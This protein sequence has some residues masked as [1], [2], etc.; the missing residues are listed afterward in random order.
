MA[1]IGRKD[2]QIGGKSR[3]KTMTK[4]ERHKIAVK[5]AK[6]RWNTTPRR[7]S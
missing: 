3:L 4:V 6:A 1:A 2:G 7:K 5:A